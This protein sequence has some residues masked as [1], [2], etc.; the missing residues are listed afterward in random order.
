MSQNRTL[1]HEY[2]YCFICLKLGISYTELL[3]QP[4]DFVKKI[5]DILDI[6]S[7]LEKRASERK[8]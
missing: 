7:T 6:T 1:P 4:A 2:T 5:A 3:K 8:K